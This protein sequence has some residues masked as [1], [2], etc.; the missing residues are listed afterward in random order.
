MEKSNDLMKAGKVTFQNFKSII[1]WEI[2][3]TQV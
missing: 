2:H 1:N 3:D